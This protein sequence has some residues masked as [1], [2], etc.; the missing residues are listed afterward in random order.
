ML[1][2]VKDDPLVSMDDLM[3]DSMAL[4]CL[5]SIDDLIKGSMADFIIDMFCTGDESLNHGFVFFATE[6]TRA[7]IAGKPFLVLRNEPRLVFFGTETISATIA[8]KRFLLLTWPF[9]GTETIKA[10][11]A[12]KRSLL[13][14]ERN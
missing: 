10:T 11:I 14:K 1:R 6:T 2:V 9:F 8:E 3:S 13:L 5:V 7:T 12:D 4:L